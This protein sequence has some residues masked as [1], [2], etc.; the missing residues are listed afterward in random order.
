[1]VVGRPRRRRG[2][3]SS[4]RRSRSAHRAARS[5]TTYA[6]R[7]RG[8]RR[9]PDRRPASTGYPGIE[10]DQER[11]RGDAYPAFGWAAAVAFVDVDLDTGEVAVRRV[12]AVDDAGRVVNPLLAAGQ[13]EGGTLQAVGYATIEEMKVVDGRY[14]NDR[15]ATYLIPTALDAP[16]I[17]AHLRRE[18][19]P[20]TRRT[21][22]RASASCRWTSSRRPSSTRSTT[23]PAPGS[24]SCR[25]R[26]SGSSRRSGRSRT[27]GSHAP[28]AEDAVVTAPTTTPARRDPS[29]SRSTGSRSR[30]PSPGGRRLLDVLRI[31]LGLTGTKEGC[32]EGEC[33]ACTVLVDGEVGGQLP[34]PGRPGRGPRGPHRRGPRRG[35][36]ARPAPGRLRRD[37]RRPVRDLHA[38]HAHGGRAFLDSGAEPRRTP[39]SARRSPATSAAAPGTGRSSTRSGWRPRS[40]ASDRRGLRRSPPSR[41]A[42]SPS[43]R[44][45]ARPGR[46]APRVTP[47]SLADG[48]R[49]A[50]RG[51]L[52][53]DR[54]RHRRPGRAGAPG[55]PTRGATWTWAPSRSC[56]GSGSMAEPSSWARPR[57]TRSCAAVPSSRSTS[58]SWPRW[59]PQVGAAQIQN[60]GTLGGNLATASP[61]GDSLPGPGR[62]RRGDRRRQRAGRA[63][64]PGGGVLPGLPADGAGRPT[65]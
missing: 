35:R 20:A 58:R 1:M 43:S 31:D 64:R 5:P 37:R 12:V 45:A 13:V 32:G 39:P 18:A 44:R 14:R 36:P 55:S 51:R 4:A 48:V 28:V 11:Y 3:D 46:P 29:A 63:E 34:G 10:W 24:P 53:A 38:G 59:R 8:P 21:A 40:R 27:S 50:G 15:L 7:R 25:P 22:P 41:P 30:S 65:S 61:A 62:G 9:H 16:A 57:P 33:G 42:R 54:G 56:A 19:V 6:R 47:R 23:R 52:A 60:R 26:R 49:P 2:G 17:E